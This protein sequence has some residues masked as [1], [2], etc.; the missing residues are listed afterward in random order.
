[1]AF[2]PND[3]TLT[4]V[5]LELDY[6]TTAMYA[7][8]YESDHVNITIII[9]RHGTPIAVRKILDI[10]DIQQLTRRLTNPVFTR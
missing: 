7:F 2:T 6:R 5:A 8:Q 3:E 9:S 4:T 1:M 10:R